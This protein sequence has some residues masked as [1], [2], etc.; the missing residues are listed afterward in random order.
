M[1]NNWVLITSP[2]YDFALSEV[3]I[4]QGLKT[5]QFIVIRS[6]CHVV[7]ANRSRAVEIGQQE[8]F[9]P[10]KIFSSLAMQVGS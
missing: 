10:H 8:P 7:A 9:L 3:K 6:I 4:E 1:K 5:N 2:F